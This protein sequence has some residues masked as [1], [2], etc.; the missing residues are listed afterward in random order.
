MAHTSHEITEGVVCPSCE[1]GECMVVLEY[2]EG[3]TGYGSDRDGNRGTTLP[4]YF[5][6]L[7]TYPCPNGCTL[8]SGQYDTIE[9]TAKGYAR[10]ARRAR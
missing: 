2:I 10:D 9:A 8:T 5:E 3:E 7:D 4:G 6:V 1:D